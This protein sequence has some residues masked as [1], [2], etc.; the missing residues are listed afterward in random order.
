MSDPIR[1]PEGIEPEELDKIEG[2]AGAHVIEIG[3]GNGRLTQRYAGRV[4]SVT[5]VDT[6]SDTIREAL[7]A[8]PLPGGARF[9][10]AEASALA[11]PFRDESF[12][13][14]LLAWS[15]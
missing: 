3:C 9:D 13:A 15:L 1:D 7:Q 5:G 8:Q 4:K 14:A 6:T 11:L 10:L 12:E 2:L